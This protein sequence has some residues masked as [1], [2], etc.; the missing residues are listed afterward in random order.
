MCVA[1]QTPSAQYSGSG[2]T[3]EFA[4]SGVVPVGG[5]SWIAGEATGFTSVF[6]P[7]LLDASQYSGIEIADVNTAKRL[8]Q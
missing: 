6:P 4:F 8:G 2:L 7:S 3:L 1:G 5:P